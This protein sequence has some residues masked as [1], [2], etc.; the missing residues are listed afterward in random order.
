MSNKGRK[1][2]CAKHFKVYFNR[3]LNISQCQVHKHLL[4]WLALVCH[5][6]LIFLLFFFPPSLSLFINSKEI[7]RKKKTLLPP[8]AAIRMPVPS[9]DK[10]C[11]KQC[12]LCCTAMT[13][14]Q[15]V[16]APASARARRRRQR[17]NPCPYVESNTSHSPSNNRAGLPSPR[18]ASVHRGCSLCLSKATQLLGISPTSPT[19]VGRTHSL[20]RAW[21]PPADPVQQLRFICPR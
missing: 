16:L 5:K 19:A 3:A 15:P 9:E 13:D 10:H 18:E 14:A 11:A 1:I 17:L 4:G 12:Q 21:V 20:H 7:K 8:G 6:R 2:Y